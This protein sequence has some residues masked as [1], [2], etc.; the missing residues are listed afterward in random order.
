MP[1]AMLLVPV[2]LM[3]EMPCPPA[4]APVA[5]VTS[6]PGLEM[7]TFVS[8]RAEELRDQQC[9]RNLKGSP[10]Q[11]EAARIVIEDGVAVTIGTGK[12]T[13]SACGA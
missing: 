13:P 8:T 9:C 1:P 6:K 7:L 3:A 4:P 10:I 5:P 12:P 11:C 2:R